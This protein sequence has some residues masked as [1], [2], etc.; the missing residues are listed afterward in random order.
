MGSCTHENA[1][2]DIK[3]PGFL[4]IF[5]HFM[6]FIWLTLEVWKAELTI[7]PSNGFGHAT[8][9]MVIQSHNY[10]AINNGL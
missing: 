6:G 7:E 1:L 2:N 9:G 3:L 8:T 5:V 4:Y 10:Q